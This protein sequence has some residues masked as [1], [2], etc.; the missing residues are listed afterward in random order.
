VN[1]TN[2]QF[3]NGSVSFGNARTGFGYGDYYTGQP[4]SI[5]QARGQQ[6][7]ERAKLW[8]TY[9]TDNWKVNNRLSISAGVRWEPYRPYQ[10]QYGWVS[11][12]EFAN[13]LSGKKSQVYVNAPAGMMFP[14]DEGYPGKGMHKGN[15]WLFAP[16]IG[17][18]FDPRGAAK[19]VVRLGYGLFYDYPIGSHNVRVSN[20]LPYG[21]QI[22]LTY[23]SLPDP[24]ANYP[25]G[26]PFP[27]NVADK[28][29]KFPT[30]GTYYSQPLDLKNTY[31]QQ[32]NMSV[33]RRLGNW[34]VT[35]NYLGS[36]TTNLWAAR[37]ANPIMYIPGNCKAGQYGL[38]KDG[39]CSSTAGANVS[40]RRMLTLLNPTIGPYYQ[41]IAETVRGGD[42]NFNSGVLSV[43]KRFTGLYTTQANYTF[44]HCIADQEAGQYLS[45]QDY[46]VYNNRK[47][48]RGNCGQDRRHNFNSS[49][50]LQS[51]YVGSGL[52]RQVIGGWQVSAIMRWLSG[53]HLTP[54]TS[55]DKGLLSTTQRPD[56]IASGEIDNPTIAKWFDTSAFIQN[57][58]GFYGNA[59]RNILNGPRSF[60]FDMGMTRR[61]KIED[62][63]L[64]FKMEAFNALNIF[65]PGNP[66]MN[67]TNQY[68]GQIRSA[69]DARIM[70]FA[71]KFSF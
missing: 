14:G 65:R 47:A 66:Q 1:M 58:P 9:I 26:N 52:M 8:G 6:D 10:H 16:R 42:A 29:L 44:G 63:T 64:E 21:G 7:F 11:H 19:E 4:S 2:N 15:P 24:W 5:S 36:K 32:W 25:G 30:A 43:Q 33:Q 41:S 60:T 50:I 51:P 59:G 70:Q 28:N 12:F 46:L 61:F 23:P 18:V 17:L 38:T 62:K 40:A 53:S 45:G 34:S 57:S 27:I 3:S 31:V 55:G 68:Y 35:V 48:D 20:S 22:T 54:A 49:F 56:R 71:L 69:S 13:F 67:I 39:P 37:Q